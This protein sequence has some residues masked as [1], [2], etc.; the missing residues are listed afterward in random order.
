MDPELVAILRSPVGGHRLR[1]DG[2]RLVS[3]GG[4]TEFAVIDGVPVLF[5]AD[6]T[7]FDDPTEIQSW[8]GRTSRW[9][10]LRSELRRLTT[11]NPV[12]RE[13]FDLLVELLTA[14]APASRRVLVVGGG[15]VGFGMERLVDEQSIKLVETD[16]YLGP[17]TRVVCDAHDLPFAAGTFDAVVIQAVLEHVIDPT[18]VVSELHRVLAPGGLIYSEVPFMQQV[19]E[20][21]YDFTR[22][23]LGGHRRLMHE[24]DELNAGAVGGPGEALAWSIR[25]FLLAC[26]GSSGW[27]RRLMV[28]LALG[29]TLP[30]RW[31]DRVLAQRPAGVDAA[32][33]TFFMGRRRDS[34]RSDSE[35]VAA[36]HGTIDTPRR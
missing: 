8:N 17:R 25:Y 5:A 36:Y 9:T 13:N 33:G 16:I 15:I 11:A 32:S 31:A 6:R 3:E 12:S 23:T 1:Y 34:L 19:H 18:R 10:A 7:L 2:E 22:W 35:I 20:G 30:L 24:F 28:T 4:G 21:A 26:A 14:N 27:G 29:M